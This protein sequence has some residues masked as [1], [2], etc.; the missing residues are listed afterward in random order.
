MLVSLF[1]LSPADVFSRA[2]SGR[3]KPVASA[4]GTAPETTTTSTF[5]AA[6]GT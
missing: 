4:T 1:V 6:T 5:R 3:E 2:E